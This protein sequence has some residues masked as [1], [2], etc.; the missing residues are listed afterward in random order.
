MPLV[1][2]QL[3]VRDLLQGQQS[4]L[5]APATAYVS[6][7]VPGTAITPQVYVWGTDL[8]EERQTMPRN[9]SAGV[10]GGGYKYLTYQLDVWLYY[11]DKADAPLIDQRFP[12]F[13]DAVMQTLRAAPVPAPLLDPQTNV[14]SQVLEIGER[15]RVRYATPRAMGDEGQLWQSCTVT[16]QVKELLQA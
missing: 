14:Q 12:G 11:I 15:M 8:T 5:L 3:Y 7:P 13:V 16:V 10:H 9:G 1:S 4:P 2:V 6:P